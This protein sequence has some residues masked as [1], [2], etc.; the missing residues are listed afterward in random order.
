MCACATDQPT[1]PPGAPQQ[2]TLVIY[3][4][5]TEQQI[6]PILGQ[7]AQ[8]IGVK[9]D[10]RYGDTSKL[11]DQLVTE[12]QDS[13]ADLFISQDAGTLGL[14][15]SKDLLA[16]LPDSLRQSVPGAFRSV[17]GH[18]VGTSA[19]ARVIAFDPKQVGQTDIPRG[20]ED[21]I[22]RRWRGKIGFVPGNAS[23]LSF[24]TA[25]RVLRGEDGARSWLRGF[26]AN[27]PRRYETHPQ[28]LDAVD[29]GEIP[30]GL[31]NHYYWFEK[32]A[33]VGVDRMRAQLHHVSGSDPAALVNIAGVGA[34][35]GDDVPLAHKAVEYLLSAPAQQFFADHL[36][37][38]PVRAGI[39]STKHRLPPLAEIKGP[40]LNL[41]RLVSVQDSRT[42]LAEV[43][44][45]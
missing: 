37:E 41:N 16:E 39:S 12:R 30:L 6:G 24:V 43:G 42:L 34:L 23:W 10:V 18:W 29:S 14:L 19:R 33:R 3:A 1:P 4:G 27:N 11:S 22:Q 44:L 45:G 15:E 35:R 5:R 2:R 20:T 31:I 38:Y 32:S 9:L 17:S 13:P 36:A 40:D 28:L 25:L 21:L 8:A 26:K 7:M